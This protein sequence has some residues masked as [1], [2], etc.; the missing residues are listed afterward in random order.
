MLTEIDKIISLNRL[1]KPFYSIYEVADLM[2]VH[3]NTVRNHI[4]AGILTAGKVG[5][6]W[7]I[8]RDDL[9]AYAKGKK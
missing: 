1:T 6:Q 8:S 9:I 3:P 5:H 4:K 2:N 7:R